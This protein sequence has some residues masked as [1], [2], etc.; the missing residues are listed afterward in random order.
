MTWQ[1]Q[2]FLAS[3]DPPVAQR[4]GGKDSWGAALRAPDALAVGGDPGVPLARCR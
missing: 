3:V 4:G 1:A 2:T